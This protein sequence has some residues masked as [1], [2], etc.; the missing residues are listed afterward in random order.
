M[1]GEE[2]LQELEHFSIWGWVQSVLRERH[3]ETSINISLFSKK[4]CFRIDPTGKT[5]YTVKAIR[6]ELKT[7]SLNRFAGC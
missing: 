5:P 6:R 3:N 4:T 7:N 2:K 1:E